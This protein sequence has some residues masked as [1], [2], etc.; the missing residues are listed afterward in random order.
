MSDNFYRDEYER[1]RPRTVTALI[2]VAQSETSPK[3]FAKLFALLLL[4]L[5][6]LLG[7][8]GLIL[9]VIPGLLFLALAVMLA[10]STF[11]AFGAWVR[12]TPWTAKLLGPYL[13]SAKGFG[14]LSWRGKLRFMLWFTARVM[15]DSMVL[16]WQMLARLVAFLGKDDK[17]RVD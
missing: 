17:P 13:D 3:W 4:L 15:V 2:R 6:V 7:M 5:C 16:L 8:V 12:R 14:N 10:S 1:R 9:P 11:P